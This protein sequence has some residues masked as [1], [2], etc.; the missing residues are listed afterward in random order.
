MCKNICSECS[1]SILKWLIKTEVSSL[2]CWLITH[3]CKS[4]PVNSIDLD[5]LTLLVKLLLGKNSPHICIYLNMLSL[6]N[7]FW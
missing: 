7:L 5:M 1:E 4:E 3:L 2:V 6:N